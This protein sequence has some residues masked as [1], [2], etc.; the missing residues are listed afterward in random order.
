MRRRGP[1]AG[2]LAAAV[3]GA[4]LA[5]LPACSGPPSEGAGEPAAKPAPSP[6]SAPAAKEAAP[7]R[8]LALS[9]NLAEIA[10]ALGLGSRVVGVSSFTTWPPAAAKLPRVGGLFDPN[11]ERMVALEP[12]LALLL[13]SQEDV[14][15]RLRAVGVDTLTVSLES[16]EDLNRTVVRIAR[17]CAVPE[18]G[19]ALAGRL[20]KELAPRPVP[21]APRTVISI[22]R[23]AGRTE[24]L[25]VA[26]PGTYLQELLGRLGAENAFSD[27]PVRYPQ[28]GMEE[29]LGRAPGLIVELQP[30]PLDT[31]GRRSL[32]ADWRRFPT[33]PAVAAG[34]LTVISGPE[35]LVIGPRLPEL[36]RR[37]EQAVREA[38][39]P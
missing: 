15:E 6:A 27:A 21:G 34:H 31:A 32:L 12:D 22:D 7:R 25:L 9:P 39:R 8:I 23:P 33:L 13:P 11:V 28:V 3:L 36:Y 16:L 20:R 10:F 30:R 5:L 18:A 37:L 24:N 19:R 26:G 4:V 2:R 35:T 17:R 38:A 1:R 14:A 29:V